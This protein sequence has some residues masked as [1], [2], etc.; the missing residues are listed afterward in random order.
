MQWIRRKK[1]PRICKCPCHWSVNPGTF[2]PQDQHCDVCE[3]AVTAAR[4]RKS[5]RTKIVEQLDDVFSLIIRIKGDWTC[6]KCKKRYDPSPDREGM[7]RNGKMTN[8]HYF[9]RGSKGLRWDERNCD[10][11][12]IWC[13]QQI[14]NAKGETIGTFN[15]KAYMIQ[16]V[17]ASQL[18]LMEYQ[19]H[20]TTKFSTPELKILL[21]QLKGELYRLL[22]YEQN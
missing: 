18:D 12:C 13:H 8:S 4:E 15:Y 6:I 22:K 20:H 17:G 16:K 7:P 21:G 1:K 9:R 2:N 10:P 14:E 5:E 3:G 11:M 19:Y